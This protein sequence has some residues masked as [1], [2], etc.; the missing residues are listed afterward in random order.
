MKKNQFAIILLALCIAFSASA[1]T[2]RKISQPGTSTKKTAESSASATTKGSESSAST[3][4]AETTPA[5]TDAPSL[6]KGGE[7]FQ[8][9][10]TAAVPVFTDTFADEKHMPETVAS[11]FYSQSIA[12]TRKISYTSS[13]IGRGVHLDDYDSYIAYPA[14]IVPASEGT[15]RFAYKPDADLFQSYNRRP[16]AWLDYGDYA[17]PFMGFFLD[18]VGWNAAFTGS[19]FL[20]LYFTPDDSKTSSISSGTWNGSS[21]TSTSADLTSTISWD[22]GKWYDIVFSY[23]ESK[24]KLAVYVD[25]YLA[26]EAAYNTP[27]SLSEGFFI[28]QGPW[29]SGIEYWPYGPHALKGTYSNL[30]IYDQ[31]IMD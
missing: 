3:T 15:I 5:A 8:K 24:G 10:L 20:G 29:L 31:A 27:L 1:C 22:S 14:G 21:W 11:S 6:K 9:N 16:A 26:G 25:S 13:E 23:S 17:P 30:R 4:T 19:F 7:T 2:I 18:T 28:G 12:S